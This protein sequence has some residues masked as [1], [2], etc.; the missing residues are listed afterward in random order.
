MS[1]VRIQAGGQTPAEIEERLAKAVLA[2][3][4]AQDREFHDPVMQQEYETEAVL[5]EQIF[6]AMIEDIAALQ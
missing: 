1:R 3:Q 4:I 5:F 2:S 6:D